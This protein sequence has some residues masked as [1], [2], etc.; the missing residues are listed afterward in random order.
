[1]R[2]LP[3]TCLVGGT[4]SAVVV[5]IKRGG[6]GEGGGGGGGVV[7]GG[8]VATVG[9]V[10]G[11]CKII[12]TSSSSGQTTTTTATTTARGWVGGL[13]PNAAFGRRENAPA[14]AADLARGTARRLLYFVLLLFLS[15]THPRSVY[16]TGVVAA[17]LP[18]TRRR[19][20]SNNIVVKYRGRPICKRNNKSVPAAAATVI[21]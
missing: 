4:G 10:S 1:M 7:G 5:I 14:A 17:D 13:S 11:T 9:K 12:K 20:F 6:E 21:I 15:C 19:A 8:V 18:G 2:G 3:A 16:A